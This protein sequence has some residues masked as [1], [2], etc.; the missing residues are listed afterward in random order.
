MAPR[1][2]GMKG[3]P[4]GQQD[5]R[6]RSRVWSAGKA[7][8]AQGEGREGGRRQYEQSLTPTGKAAKPWHSPFCLREKLRA[9]KDSEKP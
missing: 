6:R 8:L 7:C 5:T 2:E 9:D 4:G 1:P 3:P